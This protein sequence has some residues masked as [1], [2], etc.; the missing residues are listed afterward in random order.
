MA[1]S[2]FGALPDHTLP[3]CRKILYA[4][5]RNASAQVQQSLGDWTQDKLIVQIQESDPVTLLHPIFPAD[6]AGKCD[7]SALSDNYRYH[8]F[9]TFL[10][11]YYFLRMKQFYPKRI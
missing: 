1:D 8:R 2:L 7:L 4:G 9:S 11:K 10:L 3:D 5:C 6:F